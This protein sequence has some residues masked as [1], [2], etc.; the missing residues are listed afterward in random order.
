MGKNEN[1]AGEVDTW[2]SGELASSVFAIFL[3][4]YKANDKKNKY[5]ITESMM[6]ERPFVQS[7]DLSLSLCISC[8]SNDLRR[9]NREAVIHRR[10]L[11]PEPD[12]T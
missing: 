3:T 10:I 9:I 1:K 7:C 6:R 4:V 8:I 2:S 11:S 5:P 12:G